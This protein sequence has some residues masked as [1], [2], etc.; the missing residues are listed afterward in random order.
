MNAVEKDS[1]KIEVIL[2]DLPTEIK[3]SVKDNGIGIP[4]EKQK[5]LFKK[6]Y[7]VDTSHTREKGG[8]GLGLAICKGI[9]NEHNG[10]MSMNSVPNEGATF[11]FTLPKDVSEQGKLPL[12]SA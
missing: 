12:G 6:F 8:S 1:G 3:I 9:I 4:L 7:Q 11:S 5:N 2:E 10:E